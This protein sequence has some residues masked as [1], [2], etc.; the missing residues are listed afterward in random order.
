[1]PRALRS[2]LAVVAGYGTMFVVVL[3]FTVIFV[4]AL[5]LQSHHPTP[6]YL[7]INVAYSFAAALVGGF[8]TAKLA[9][10]RPVEHGIALGAVILL[11]GALFLVHPPVGQP[12]WYGWALTFLAP[13]WAILGAATQR[14]T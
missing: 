6:G 4:K 12:V 13:V 2:V 8:V 1:M 11:V 7:V 10:Y 3:V 9:G 5:H 14:R